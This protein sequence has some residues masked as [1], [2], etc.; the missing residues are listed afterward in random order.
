MSNTVYE[1]I[2]NELH[3]ALE[4]TRMVRAGFG[5]P[6]DRIVIKSSH[7]DNQGFKTGAEVH[8]T[9]FII[10]ATKLYR[11]S[12]IEG[13]ILRALHLIDTNKE[14]LERSLE[15]A[16]ALDKVNIQRIASLVERA[17]KT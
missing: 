4:A 7:F 9:E 2:S 1:Q 13:P 8:P 16:E 5:F 14:L 17:N 11:G 10:E 12:W 3:A 15:L 6:N